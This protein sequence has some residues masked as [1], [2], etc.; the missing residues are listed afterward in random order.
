MNTDIKAGEIRPGNDYIS[1]S[2]GMVNILEA[3]ITLFSNL[4]YGNVSIKEIAKEAGTSTGLIYHH[5]ADKE[6]LFKK[7]IY[8]AVEKILCDFE[9]EKGQSSAAEFDVW[10]HVNAIDNLR[11]QRMLIMLIDLRGVHGGLD[12]VD[13]CI[14]AFYDLESRIIKDFLTE[15]N[16]YQDYNGKELAGLTSLVSI[17]LDGV[18]V[19]SMI[20]DGFDINSALAELRSLITYYR[21][22]FKEIVR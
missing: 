11:L 7:S 5:Y 14:T 6:D 18:M 9:T 12:G 4:G 3:S 2:A 20:R 10:L 19:R 21:D 1:Q 13:E 22:H 16:D 17:C 8:R 15:G